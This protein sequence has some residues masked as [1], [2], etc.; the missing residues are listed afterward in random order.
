MPFLFLPPVPRLDGSGL[1]PSLSDSAF[2]FC[3]S[4]AGEIDPL[5]MDEKGDSVVFGDEDSEEVELSTPGHST[6][7]KKR[8]STLFSIVDPRSLDSAS[9][10]PAP[11]PP[12]PAGIG[13][14][15]VPHVLRKVVRMAV[16]AGGVKAGVV[17]D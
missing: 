5:V 2:R 13:S 16:I 14:G 7:S 4:R 15:A 17:K 10:A 1:L 6:R 3:A 8:L 11:W 9:G 12:S